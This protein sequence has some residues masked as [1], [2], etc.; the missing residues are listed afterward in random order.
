MN[1]TITYSIVVPVYGNSGSITDLL[2]RLEGIS[3]QLDRELEVIFVVDGS[4]DDSY[5]V[6]TAQLPNATFATQL[7]QHSRNFG[8]FAAIRTGMAHARGDFIAVMAADMQEPPELAIEFFRVLA[9][10]SADVTVGRRESRHD[11]RLS[12]FSSSAFWR[13]YRKWVFPDMPEGGVDIFA[14]NRA[15]VEEVLRLD[16]SH[17]SLVGLLYWVGFR[18]VEVPYHRLQR[19]HG[20]SGWSFSKKRKYLLDSIFSFTDLPLR[21]L[22]SIGSTGAVITALS[23]FAVLASFLLG[24]IREPGYTPL[25]LVILFST[26]TLLVALGIVGSYV[27]RAFENTKRRPGSIVMT[28]WASSDNALGQRMPNH[29]EEKK[30]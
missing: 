5:D 11:P 18:R 25:M 26:F 1:N 22:I 6:L 21:L 30:P 9:S 10:G 17:S 14:C 19:E 4:P 28:R 12:G 3:F 27:W 7:L 16:E 29:T 8:S 24:G 13:L 20:E 23:A 2:E 15:V